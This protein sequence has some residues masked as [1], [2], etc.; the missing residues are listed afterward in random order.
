MEVASTVPAAPASLYVGDLHPDITDGQLFD[1]F[2]EFKSLAS[3]RVCR[4]S[5]SGK[6]LR[7]GY[8]NFIAPL[9]AI[10]AIEMKNHTVLNGKTIRVMWSHR[11]A[12]ARKSGVGNV[13][14]KNI[15]DSIDSM[16][17]QE[18]FA[19]F[20]DISSCKV[21][22]T[23][24]GKSKGYGFVQFVSEDSANVA[25]EK[26]NGE[27]VGGKQIYV[28]KF[29]R[30]SDRDLTNPDIKYTNLYIKNFDSD[31]TEEVLQ[32]KF[33]QFGNVISLVVIKNENG[34]SKGFGFVNFDN[35]DDAKQAMEVMNGSQLGSKSLYVA[36]AQK[37]A[38]REQI[39][40]RVFEE[41]RK[42]KILKCM[43]S[44]VYIKNIKDDVNDE[45]LRELFSQ[46]GSITSTKLMRDDKGI[47][48][49]FGFVCYCTPDEAIKAVSTFHG[50]MF[51]QKP[52][53]VAI[54]QRKE[55]RQAQ[56]Q[57]QHAQH[58]A[59][60]AVPSTTV[61]PGGYPPLYYTASGAVS[62]I[63]TQ[64]GLIYQPLGVNPGWKGNGFAP[65]PRIAFQ[66]S[67]VPLIPNVRH[68]R[69]NRGR[70]NGHAFPQNGES[71][72]VVASEKSTNQQKAGQVK[73]APNR[74]REVNKASG[75]S[76]PSLSSDET[77]SPGSK[78][79]S[80]MLAAAT[81]QKQKQILGERLY[82]LVHKHRPDLVAKITGMLLEMD[83]SELLLL[84]ESPESLAAK[85]KEAVQVLL[86][87]KT[88]NP[89]E[90]GFC[91]GYLTSE[92]HERD[93]AF[94][95]ARGDTVKDVKEIPENPITS[96]NKG[97]STIILK[98][99]VVNY[100]L[101]HHLIPPPLLHCLPWRLHLSL[102]STSPPFVVIGTPSFPN[103]LQ[104][105]SHTTMQKSTSP[106]FIDSFA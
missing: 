35:P 55:A 26:L 66:P 100:Y 41:K 89:N 93:I 74:W 84:L 86:L 56:L 95:Y 58:I 32:E 94:N 49:G 14:V 65:A 18:M 9:D 7:Y 34:A 76:S 43:G 48:K 104:L 46:C 1:A 8:V 2:S 51:H 99:P 36:R 61:L 98:A 81:P 3:V 67:P 47:S 50:Y 20:G 37:K 97:R 80:S 53:Y 77:G 39:L 45:E 24:D 25:I 6:S 13:F 17:L 29:L 60:L 88:N 63:P 19:K 103:G 62:Q 40:R 102:N 75:A 16:K 12:N 4:D 73:Y 70:M 42:E 38:E 79:L 44:N 64:Q 83:N 57:L 5:S 23:E 85:V 106:P 10:H 91:P 82:P 33:S 15:C 105:H 52:L 59:G 90:D 11:D 69:Q 28:G 21:V 92:N 27:T 87:S 31:I 78:T 71:K 68:K 30:K 101:P 72:S 22:T 54:A 96:A